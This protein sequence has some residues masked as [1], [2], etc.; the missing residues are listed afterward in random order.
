MLSPDPRSLIILASGNTSGSIEGLTFVINSPFINLSAFCLIHLN[1]FKL[2]ESIPWSKYTGV[3]IKSD[4][5]IPD[6]TLTSWSK[7]GLLLFLSNWNSSPTF[8][9]SVTSTNVTST[10]FVPL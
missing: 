9:D 3:S 8:T 2:L 10:L 6:T 1:D 7:P 4:V 5:E